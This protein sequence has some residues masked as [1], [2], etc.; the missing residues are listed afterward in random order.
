MQMLP[1]A[2]CVEWIENARNVGWVQG[3]GRL[4]MSAESIDCH[5][6]LVLFEGKRHST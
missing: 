3:K 1:Q 2:Y 5:C 4:S 6:V